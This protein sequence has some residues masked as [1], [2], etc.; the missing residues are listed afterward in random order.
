LLLP[1]NTDGTIPD[2]ELKTIGDRAWYAFNCLPRERG[3]MP[4][5]RPLEEKFGLSNGALKKLFT[6]AVPRADKLPDHL[7]A[8]RVSYEWLVEGV[9]ERPRLTAPFVAL[10]DWLPSARLVVVP[11][12][13]E[14]DPAVALIGRSFTPAERRALE[15]AE[16]LRGQLRWQAMVRVAGPIAGMDGDEVADML[17]DVAANR[18]SEIQFRDVLLGARERKAHGR[19]KEIDT[20]FDPPPDADEETLEEKQIAQRKAAAA[21]RT[22]KRRS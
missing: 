12:V 5:V 10:N 4:K 13:T 6:G 21:K 8:L 20:L 2:V 22:K 11:P 18:S 9:G 7:R 15:E 17:R 1:S 3:G 19:A 14:E 16:S